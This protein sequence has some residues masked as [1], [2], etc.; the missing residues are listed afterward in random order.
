M[1]IIFY[2][3]EQTKLIESTYLQWQKVG[4]DYGKNINSFYSLHKKSFDFIERIKP[5]GDSFGGENIHAR[6]YDKRMIGSDVFKDFSTVIGLDAQKIPEI[7]ENQ[8]IIAE[9]SRLIESMDSLLEIE[10]SSREKLVREIVRLSEKFRTSS[11]EKI[12]S[13]ELEK[14]IKLFYHEG[15][16]KF[17]AEYLK[18][19]M[20]SF[21]MKQIADN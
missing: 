8:S 3:R 10:K 4:S 15:N 7:R 17:A 16:K 1:N 2:I 9:F 6:V 12:I 5:W 18:E 19:P 13:E 14:E 11:K 20:A 21:F